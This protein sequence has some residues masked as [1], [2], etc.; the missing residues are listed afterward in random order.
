MKNNSPTEKHEKQRIEPRMT[1]NRYEIVE[2]KTSE[3]DA[4]NQFNLLDVSSKGLCFVVDE[5]SVVL[6]D[7][8]V[9]GILK[10]KYYPPVSSGG[11]EYLMTEIR[12]ITKADQEGF[13]GQ[14]FVGLLIDE[15][16][17]GSVLM[18]PS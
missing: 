1:P 13:K 10:M 8:N 18:S 2:F 7:L 14:C 3:S 6:K 4:L 16:R 11:A 9:G 15:K 5:D 17:E 12:H